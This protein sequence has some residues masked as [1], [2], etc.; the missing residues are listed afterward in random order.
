VSSIIF[1]GTGP[2]G[3][4]VARGSQSVLRVVYALFNMRNLAEEKCRWLKQTYRVECEVVD[5]SEN[6][7]LLL[8]I[9]PD[10]IDLVEKG[11]HYAVLILLPKTL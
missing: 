3:P 6:K 8:R 4:T 11:Y 9:D 7:S 10:L 1:S 5:F 2:L